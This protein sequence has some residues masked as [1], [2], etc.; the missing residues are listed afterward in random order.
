MAAPRTRFLFWLLACGLALTACNG[1]GDAVDPVDVGHDAING[2]IFITPAGVLCLQREMGGNCVQ[3]TSSST[4]ELALHK[5]I[6]DPEPDA[7][8]INFDI[9][10]YI[11]GGLLTDTALTTPSYGLAR[12]HVQAGRNCNCFIVDGRRYG[13]VKHQ[14]DTE[15]YYTREQG[16]AAGFNF[17]FSEDMGQNPAWYFSFGEGEGTIRKKGAGWF[18]QLGLLTDQ[19]DAPR[20]RKVTYVGLYYSLSGTA[21]DLN[22]N[23]TDTLNI[24]LTY[25]AELDLHT[26]SLSGVSI[27]YTDPKAQRH[28]RLKLPDLTFK[29][30]RLHGLSKTQRI[31]IEIDGPGEDLRPGAPHPDTPRTQ[32]DF[33]IEGL[34]GEILGKQAALIHLVG[35][36]PKGV[37]QV[38]LVRKELF[39]LMDDPVINFP[40]IP[41]KP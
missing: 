22:E 38:M 21:K 6:T 32:H 39:E 27:D 20:T 8:M 40:L 1:G 37:F 12:R 16:G 7:P 5:A 4:S 14:R 36:G 35:G 19:T 23:G 24:V 13:H 29:H 9:S 28:T 25:E 26:G 33:T 30:S 34:E 2:D 41:A 11:V 3:P 18:A 15:F 17:T 31:D 10:G